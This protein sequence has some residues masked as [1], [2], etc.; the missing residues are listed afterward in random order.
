MSGQWDLS[1]G[2]HSGWN[3][4]KLKNRL[5]KFLG[6]GEGEES[7]MQM[8]AGEEKEGESWGCPIRVKEEIHVW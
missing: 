6:R 3:R 8:K 5:G 4:R 2:N 7:H 1:R